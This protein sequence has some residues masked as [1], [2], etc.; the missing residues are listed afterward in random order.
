MAEQFGFSKRDATNAIVELEKTGVVKRVFRTLQAGG[1]QIPNVL[2]LD[3]NVE[4]LERLTYPDKMQEPDEKSRC[5]PNR[6]EVSLKT[7]GG[8][9][10]I[11]ETLPPIA[12]RGVTETGDTN[13]KSTNREYPSKNISYPSMLEWVKGQ[14]SYDALKHDHP[15]DA[16]IDEIV[17]IMA[18]I[19]SSD[20]ETIR[21]NKE[22]K[23]AAVV[24]GQFAKL[25]M[26]HLEY[27]LK[28]LDENH[29][30]ARNIRAVLI[31]ALYNSVLTI[32]SY[33]GNLVQYHLHG[34]TQK[35]D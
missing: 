13:T 30:K 4:V 10:G 1:Q 8:I 16:R 6:I 24:K 26:Q 5:P 12:G 28:S 7:A 19:M 33:Y 21:V 17:E 14:V 20:A 22:N 23:P 3:L 32:S 2:F 29:T 11:S 25:S 9:P 35:E 15:Y 18:D 31:T 34:G 27:V